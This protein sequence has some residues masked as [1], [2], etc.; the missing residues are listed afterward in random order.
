[1]KVAPRMESQATAHDDHVTK[2]PDSSR[3]RVK[4]NSPRYS[5]PHSQA[6][7][8]LDRVGGRGGGTLQ[9]VAHY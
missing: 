3:G 5:F 6:P 9:S 4:G 8:L 1:M 7:T 2:N